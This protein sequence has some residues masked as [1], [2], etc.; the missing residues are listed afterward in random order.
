MILRSTDSVTH[1]LFTY[2][3][4]SRI[5]MTAIALVLISAIIVYYYSA[6][7]L[8]SIYA[9]ELLLNNTNIESSDPYITDSN[10]TLE[11]IATG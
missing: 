10:F 7:A 8:L 1:M 4:P 2:D 3:K 11:T 5:V 9:E 6:G